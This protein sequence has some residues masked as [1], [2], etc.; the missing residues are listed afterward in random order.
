MTLLEGWHKMI[1]GRRTR[2]VLALIG[3]MEELDRAKAEEMRQ[4][5]YQGPW[6]GDAGTYANELKEDIGLVREAMK[7]REHD[8]PGSTILNRPRPPAS[9]L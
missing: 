5:E 3:R 4:R 8:S 1:E 9:G 2:K 6:Y 7:K